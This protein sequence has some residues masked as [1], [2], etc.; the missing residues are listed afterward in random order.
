MFCHLANDDQ[1]GNET[2][3]HSFAMPLQNLWTNR[4]SGV[5]RVCQPHHISP[6]M[7]F[8]PSTSEISPPW[9][10]FMFQDVPDDPAAREALNI[11]CS[12]GLNVSGNRDGLRQIGGCP[13]GQR[14][15]HH[16]PRGCQPVHQISDPDLRRI[17][18]AAGIPTGRDVAPAPLAQP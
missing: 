4:L 17:R 2:R 11:S 1:D 15:F 5:V 9:W 18:N 8:M 16:G 13:A 6:G 10:D 14:A 7:P 3:V 12:S